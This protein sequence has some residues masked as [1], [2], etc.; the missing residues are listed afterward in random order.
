MA[1]D[2]RKEENRLYSKANELEYIVAKSPSDDVLNEYE[3]VK[4]ALD[5]IKQRRGRAAILRSQAVWIEEGEKSSKYFLRM[6]KRRDAQ[7][8][9]TA[10]IM[11][12]GNIIRGNKTLLDACV[13][14]FRTFYES[15]REKARDM[16]SFFSGV[17]IP[18]LSENDRKECE[19]PITK[20][21]C[22]D[23]LVK[24]AR[25]KAAG[26][27][28]FT[29]EFFSFFW[30]DIG[31]LVVAYFNHACKTGELFISHRRGI[32]TL[33]PKKG[34]Q[35]LLTNKRPI[36]LLDVLYKIVAKVMANRLCK[37]IGKLV[38]SSQTGFMKRRYIG[39]NVRLISDV[40][41]YCKMDNIEGLLMALDYRSAF[42]SIEHDF[43]LHTLKLFNFGP[44]FQSWVRLLYCNTLLTVKNNGFTS[45]WFQ[46]LRGTF[47]GSPL[48]G[49]L[50]NLVVELLAI[51]IRSAN[52]VKGLTINQHEVKLS[53]YADDT[54]LFLR[55]SSSVNAVIQ[56]LTAFS[57]ASGLELNVKKCNI[58]WLGPQCHRRDS[59]CGIVAVA[60]INI[61]GIWFSASES[62]NED[63][64]VPVQKSI[65]DTVNEWSERNLTIKGRIV[66]SKM[67]L[68]SQ[69]V[70]VASCCPIARTDLHEIQS[71]IMKFIWRGRPP[72]VAMGT[73]C[74]NIR[75]GGLN[76]VNVAHFYAALR[77]AWL[78]RIVTCTNS[79]WRILL[80]AR[81]G[82]F[83]LNDAL[84]I[85]KGKY[86][87]NSVLIPEFYR[88]IMLSFQD[89]CQKTPIGTSAEVR[90]QSLWYSDEI[91][92]NNL[93]VFS[94]R[95]YDV[96]LKA[97][98]DVTDT[99]GNIMSVNAIKHKYPDLQLN[100][101]AI[102]SVVSAI[103]IEW[104]AILREGGGS[105][106]VQSDYS[107]I[108][109]RTN[110]KRIEL[111]KCKCKHF[112]SCLVETREPAAV[113]RWRQLEI[114]PQ[115]W[116]D[117]YELPYKCTRSTR[118][119]ALHFRIVNRYIPTRKYLCTRGVVGSPLCLKCFEVDD[120]E[121]F[122]VECIDVKDLWKDIL[123]KLKE[124]FKL[125]SNFGAYQSLI[126]GSPEDPP[127]VNL[128]VLITKQYIVNCKLSPNDTTQEPSVL[129]L[130][131]VITG[132]AQAE[133]IIAKEHNRVQEY[134]EK[135]KAFLDERG[136]VAL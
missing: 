39:E 19:G 9:I 24:M 51:K 84:K 25:N 112:Y 56:I 68:A 86:F 134:N 122:F 118:L 14:Y 120:L 100:F 15:K 55:D 77:L 2:L 78:T 49:L 119:Q 96:G 63:N 110:Q 26:I 36:C 52:S 57:I 22:M 91:K 92:V 89:I 123:S 125:S 17:N 46:C 35:M 97:I 5:D 44:E 90:L 87:L 29:A 1:H 107:E 106:D 45:N 104:R 21:E 99:N 61:L 62:C 65:R 111:K 76:A 133:K 41:D 101:L 38:N 30:E 93:P 73:L 53:Q 109:L 136:N 10:L 47:Q 79:D 28:G 70:Y 12:D 94:K 80:Q 124:V 48:S 113:Q 75:H 126:L 121:H 130:L 60:K 64:I 132:Y 103:P 69:M 95:M 37:V 23:A 33:I 83:S 11:D 81:L 115:C 13:Q 4:A 32:I 98:N 114:R 43:I 58:M 3:E 66:V 135:W 27:S 85:R 8:N 127:I 34:N 6:C 40:I 108:H 88:D 116:R 18:Q 105:N 129:R 54:T 131:G 16:H 50:F 31:D 59:V 102:Q 20:Q 117:I 71:R 72:K 67:L 128:I 82:V 7:R 74:Q 42:D